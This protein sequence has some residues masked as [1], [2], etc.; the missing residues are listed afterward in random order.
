MKEV[1]PVPVA[2]LLLVASTIVTVGDWWQ[3]HD[4]ETLAVLRRVPGVGE[5]VD[6][7]TGADVP[8]P[9]VTIA[10][11]ASYPPFAS[12]DP[13]GRLVGFEVELGEELGSRVADRTRL[14]NM[15]GG[16]ILI[17]ALSSRK[18]DAIIAGL[19]YLPEAA[20]QVTY[21]GS[22]FE[23]GSVI[24]ARSDRKGLRTHGDLAG[25]RVAVEMGSLADEAAR[26][27]QRR[28]PGMDLVHLGDLDRVLAAVAGDSVD[29]AVV[30]KAYLPSGSPSMAGLRQVGNPLRPEPYLIAVRRVDLGLSVA[31]NRE[32]EAMRAMGLLADMERKWFFEGAM[33]GEREVEETSWRST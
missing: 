3:H 17:D 14:V 30:D 10:V 22:Y 13:S 12:V 2:L 7:A 31:I 18:I 19:T 29:A 24:L 8:V 9:A 11:D 5:Q 25:K 32:L 26:K 16:D 23:S 15:D 20:R 4:A 21:A 28:L 1:W 6:R 27:L 33:D